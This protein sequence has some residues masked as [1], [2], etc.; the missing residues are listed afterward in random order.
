MK[1][2]ANKRFNLDLEIRKLGQEIIKGDYTKGGKRGG[3]GGGGAGAGAGGGSYYPGSCVGT[4]YLYADNMHTA[5]THNYALN[6][7]GGG[8][9]CNNGMCSWCPHGQTHSYIHK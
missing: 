3:G 9:K 7:W 4:H 5:E 6:I 8:V 1:K 2:R